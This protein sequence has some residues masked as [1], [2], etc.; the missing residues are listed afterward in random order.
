MKILT[1]VRISTNIRKN[2]TI[3]TLSKND[4]LI[5][6][7]FVSVVLIKIYNKIQLVELF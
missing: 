7:E 1:F 3:L 2:K 4:N 5:P 6:T